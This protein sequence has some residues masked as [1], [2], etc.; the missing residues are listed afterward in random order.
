M[1]SLQA[2]SVIS[3]MMITVALHLVR[4]IV[5][6]IICVVYSMHF[7]RLGKNYVDVRV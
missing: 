3:L 5:L 1:W 6:V 2:H 4:I 7:N